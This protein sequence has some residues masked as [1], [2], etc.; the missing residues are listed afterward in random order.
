VHLDDVVI[1]SVVA[2]DCGQ[3]LRLAH[4]SVAMRGEVA[5][6]STLGVGQVEGVVAASYQRCVVV[7]H[8]I[9]D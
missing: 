6:Q 3:D 8:Q 7:D 2:P 1:E 4:H 9:R 5:K